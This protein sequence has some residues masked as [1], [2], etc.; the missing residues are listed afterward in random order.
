MAW[1]EERRGLFSLF[2]RHGGRRY[3]HATGTRDGREAEAMRR[4]LEANLLDLENGRLALPEGADLTVFLLSDGR[5]VRSAATPE[6]LTLAD[7]LARYREAHGRALEANSLRTHAYQSAHL[8][9]T[10]GEKFPARTLTL[11]DLQRHVDRRARVKG[12]G[13]RPLSPVT[14]RKEVQ[15]LSAAWGWGAVRGLVPGP[16]PARGL[17][18]PKG[19]EK[20]PFMT[21]EEAARRTRG[22]TEA[23]AAPFW[24]ALFL[25][26]PEVEEFLGFAEKAA[27]FAWVP[28]AMRFAAHTGA[29]RSEVIR[30]RPGDVGGGYVH[31][32]E[33]KRNR[34]SHTTRR[35]PLSPGLGAALEAWAAVRP[36][37]PCL[38]CRA[39][40]APLTVGSMSHHF[41]QTLLGS[42]WAVV[43]G[44]HVLRHSFASNCAAAG[45]DQRLIDAWMGHQNPRTAARY[46]H[47]IP[48]AEATALALVF[49]RGGEGGAPPSSGA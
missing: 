4:R 19:V 29:R 9:R 26:A 8:V 21:R 14:L 28:P 27:R 18:Y 25:T 12:R 35:V 10:L 13:G 20:P 49:G 40:G 46:R 37:S 44:W 23:E 2:Y 15:L 5:T 6:V 34:A 42:A 22:L 43:R 45:V 7:L 32:R 30:V 41:E 33:R 17:V 3:R 47:L 1:L 48:S 24:D 39:D 31:L 36:D 16:F 38:F 11:S